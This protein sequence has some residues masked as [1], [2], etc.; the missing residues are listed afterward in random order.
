MADS[1][2][3]LRD[4]A[5]SEAGLAHNRYSGADIEQARLASKAGITD[6]TGKNGSDLLIASGNESADPEVFGIS[7]ATVA[8]AGGTSIKIYGEGFTGATAVTLKGAAATAVVVDSKNQITCT[9]PA[10]TAGAGDV[11]VTTPNGSD[12]LTNGITY[13]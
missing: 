7:H 5:V 6:L 10:R 4:A 2:E 8:T 13:A 11:V 1:V 3:I 12:T 9:T